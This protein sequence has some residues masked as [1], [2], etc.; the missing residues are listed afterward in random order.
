[1]IMSNHYKGSILFD[2]VLMS[3]HILGIDALNS[4]YKMIAADVNQS[5]SI[6]TVDM[7]ELR[8]LILYINTEFENNTSWRF[9]PADFSFDDP[10]NPFVSP[11]PEFYKIDKLEGSMINIDF[12]GIKTGDL[13]GS[14]GFSNGNQS[15][16]RNARP[17]LQIH[18]PDQVLQ[19]GESYQVNFRAEAFADL[20]GL[21]FSLNFDPQVLEFVSIESD[22]P[23]ISMQAQHFGTQLSKQGLLTAAWGEYPGKVIKVNDQLFSLRFRAKASGLL[24]QVL[25]LSSDRTPIAVFDS[26][27]QDYNLKLSFDQDVLGGVEQE[28]QLFQNRPNPFTQ[29]TVIPFFLAEATR[30]QLSVFDV[31]GRLIKQI[32]Q[33]YPA[34]YHEVTLNSTA[35]P[36]QAIYYYQLQ[37]DQFAATKKMVFTKAK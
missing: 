15:E 34:G 1:M 16:D 7:V 4:P 25:H 6:T 5:G 32:N 37:T 30:V 27:G 17:A 24:S 23:A 3:R 28:T 33:Q 20:T 14:A 8:K 26:E 2:L 12:T 35:L 22:D 21:Q 10:A 11:F 36:G 19:A 31:S 18:S 29:E 9:I 13:N